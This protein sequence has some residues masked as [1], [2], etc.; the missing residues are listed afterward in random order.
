MIYGIY[1]IKIFIKIVKNLNKYKPVI[2][3][4]K[5][6]VQGEN[7][8]NRINVG[9]NTNSLFFFIS[10]NSTGLFSLAMYTMNMDFKIP[11]YNMAIKEYLDLSKFVLRKIV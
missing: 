10:D 5:T 9:I 6:I 8:P 7:I 3:Y 1:M 4:S 11:D 2:N